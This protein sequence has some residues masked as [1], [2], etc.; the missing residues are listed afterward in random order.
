MRNSG[1]AKRSSAHAP[2]R[3]ERAPRQNSEDEHL[4]VDGQDKASSLRSALNRSELPQRLQAW[5]A[6]AWRRAGRCGVAAA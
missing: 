2:C 4:E 1:P 6:K 3:H 5:V